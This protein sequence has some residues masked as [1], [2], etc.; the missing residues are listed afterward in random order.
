MLFNIVPNGT[1]DFDPSGYAWI[2]SVAD[3]EFSGLDLPDVQSGKFVLNFDGYSF[4][5]DPG[6]TFDFLTY[7][8]GG[9]TDFDLSFDGSGPLPESVFGLEFVNSD[10]TVV[11]IVSS[12][13]RPKV[14]RSP[15][16]RS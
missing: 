11:D 8:P 1:S 10:E 9:I 12:D 7:V 6:N 4:D 3:N 5:L 13:A 15:V 14:S 2:F 16:R